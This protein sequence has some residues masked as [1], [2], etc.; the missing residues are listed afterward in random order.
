LEATSHLAGKHIAPGWRKRRIQLESCC[1]LGWKRCRTR[2]EA[3]SF[4]PPDPK[5]IIDQVE[6]AEFLNSRDRRQ[7]LEN[8]AGFI[9]YTIENQ[10]SVPTNFVMSRRLREQEE[11]EQKEQL[12]L[13][14]SLFE[15]QLEYDEWIEK[16]VEQELAAVYP[17]HELKNK[18]KDVMT[19]RVRTDDR[20]SKM[21]LLHQE[22]LA[23]Q[24]LRKDTNDELAVP[25]FDQWRQQKH[26]MTLF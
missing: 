23:L 9:I 8:P 11:R 3:T 25:S 21:A 26:Q 4:D 24:F 17:G 15:L 14:A 1:A 19:Q 6:Y 13:D 5:M 18:I 2:L 10:L 16:Q 22:A 20:F 7:K 12:E